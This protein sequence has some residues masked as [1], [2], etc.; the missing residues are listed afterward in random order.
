MNRPDLENAC[1]PLLE[2]V[3]GFRSLPREALRMIAGG[4]RERSATRDQVLCEKGQRLDGFYVLI[5]GRVKLAVLSSDGAERVLDIVL[6]GQ[7]FA[8]AAAFLCEPYPLHAQ[9]LSDAR[10]LHVR[11]PRVRRAMERW[12]EVAFR[13]LTLMAQC[14]QRLTADLEA[15]CLHSAGQRVAGFLLREAE[16]NR[17][18]A[19]QASLT[20]PAAKSVVASCLN[21]SPETFS[22]ELHGLARRGLIEIERR[23]IRI[24]SLTQLRALAGIDGPQWTATARWGRGPLAMGVQPS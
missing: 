20:L 1:L 13:M 22:R 11:L 21:V 18:A 24:T 3:P 9:A 19:D 23:Q 17:A 7:T 10:L 15:C 6:P 16:T 14:T 5:E 8:E 12:P 4:C 2:T